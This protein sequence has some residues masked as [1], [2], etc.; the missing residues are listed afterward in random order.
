MLL[1]FLLLFQKYADD[2]AGLPEA[3]AGRMDLLPELLLESRSQSTSKSYLHGLK[4][5]KQWVISNCLGSRDI[6]PARALHVAIYLAS[7]IQAANSPSPLIHA[8]YSL[9][10]IHDIG[11]Q[12]STTD[13]QLVKNVF[14]AGKRRFAKAVCKKELITSEI[15]EK[16]MMHYIWRM[17]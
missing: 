11:D 15:I 14:E 2:V 17:I 7:I 3:L 1:F 10:W 13:S 6:L 16:F 4:K 12:V 5:W 8:L 9:K